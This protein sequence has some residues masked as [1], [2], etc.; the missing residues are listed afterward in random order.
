VSRI[1]AEF[2]R[3][4]IIEV[5]YIQF[6]AKESVICDLI[7]TMLQGVDCFPLDPASPALRTLQSAIPATP[8]FIRD[9]KKAKHDGET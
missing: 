8:E 6:G 4:C 9:F 7:I 3:I 5:S 1:A 2:T